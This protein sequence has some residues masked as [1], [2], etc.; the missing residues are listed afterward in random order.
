MVQVKSNGKKESGIALAIAR[1]E[2]VG[3]GTMIVA[4]AIGAWL[5]D[6]GKMVE[7]AVTYAAPVISLVSAL[8][9][10][11]A[12]LKNVRE[13]KTVVAAVYASVFFL[14]LIGLT[15]VF[16]D[17]AYQNVPL[18]IGMCLLGTVAALILPAG[19]GRKKRHRRVG[20]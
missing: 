20:R 18:G 15:A 14:T 8:A 2:A 13:G 17:G 5:V 9:G 12:A 19:K 4:C 11:L 3:I 1:G 10:V 6:G 16:F 7:G